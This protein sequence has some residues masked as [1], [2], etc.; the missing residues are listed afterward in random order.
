M[1]D[2]ICLRPGALWLRLIH[3]PARRMGQCWRN[4]GPWEERRTEEGR[5]RMRTAARA[6]PGLPLYPDAPSRSVHLLTGRRFWEQT[7]FCLHS[8][9]RNSP[10]NLHAEIYDDGTLGPE[11]KSILGQLGAGIRIHPISE[12]RDQLERHLPAA[13]FPWLRERWQN[14]PNIRKL[15]DPHLGS[16]GWKLVLDSDL[17]FFR[18]PDALLTWLD[19]PD[20]PLH[21]VDIEESYGYP[22]PLME[23]LARAPIAPL[24]NV[25][26]CGLRSE[27]LD[28]ERIEHWCVQLHENQRPSYYLEQAL[29]AMLVAG[30]PCAVLPAADY[31]TCPAGSEAR[32]PRAVMHHYVAHSKRWYFQQH[33]QRF[34]PA[35]KPT[36]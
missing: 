25:G 2:P 31:V 32:E 36:S 20:R 15:I 5:T 24:V 16:T 23:S 35:S 27:E 1:F 34:V 9:A 22:R 14:Y 11:E 12:I 30:C 8:L 3:R 33:W 21:A 4:G 18:R 7:T 6:L 28:W 13:R 19:A 17:L 26:L 29:V 10:V